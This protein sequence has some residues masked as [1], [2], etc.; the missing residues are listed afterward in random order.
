M[1]NLDDAK[2]YP[3]ADPGNMRGHIEALPQQCADA[4][5]LVQGIDFPAAYRS[6]RLVAVLGMG[7]SAIGGALLTGLVAGTCPVP[8]MP[9]GG[10]DLPAYVREDALVIASSHSGNTEETLALATQAEERGARIV[11]V[12][13]GGELAAQAETK[14]WPLVRFHYASAPRAALGYSFTL[15]WGILHRLD[16][17]KD[18]PSDLE[19]AIA[20]MTAWQQELVPGVP[21]D[22]NPAKQLAWRLVDRAPVIYGAGFLAPVARRWKGQFNENSK[23][24]SFWEELPELNHNA[25]VGYEMPESVTDRIAVIFLRTPLEDERI[26]ARWEA[27]ADLLHKADVALETVWGHGTGKLAQMLSLI[28]FGDYVSYYL[29]LLNRIDPTPV[30]AIDYLK[31]RLA[32]P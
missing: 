11:A 7:G 22:H 32:K 28:H 6:P 9:I 27:T 24:W 2:T 12:T 3:Q 31:Q 18:T 17:S 8:V 4:W 29:A 30:E 26:Q 15:L 5:H 16:I 20:V 13:S 25:V 1:F 10:Y 21:A 19:E 14:G 23:T